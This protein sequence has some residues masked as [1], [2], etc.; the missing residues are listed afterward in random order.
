MPS[1]E[2]NYM[3]IGNLE[4]NQHQFRIEYNGLN[5]FIDNVNDPRFSLMLDKDDWEIMKNFIDEQ[6]DRK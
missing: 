5:V 4:E 6:F 3:L 1:S 2:H